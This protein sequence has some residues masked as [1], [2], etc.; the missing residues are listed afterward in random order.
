LN[1]VEFAYPVLYW[2]A[3]RPSYRLPYSDIS[4][5]L[6]KKLI[7]SS[8]NQNGIS[9]MTFSSLTMKSAL[10]ESLATLESTDR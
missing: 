3:Y 1:N 7:N 8:L 4:G 6:A 9:A 2:Y 5:V 10:R